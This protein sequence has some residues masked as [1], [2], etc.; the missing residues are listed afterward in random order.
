M[1][2]CLPVREDISGIARAIFTKF[3]CMLPMSVTRSSFG[4][5]TIVR[6]GYRRVGGDGSFG[7]IFGNRKLNSL[8]CCVALFVGSYRL[9]DRQTHDYGTYRASI[10]SRGK[11]RHQAISAEITLVDALKPPLLHTSA[12]CFLFIRRKTL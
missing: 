8:D 2:V 1:S 6:I 4:M 7:E 12:K 9:A 11:K 3:L 5:L 10:A